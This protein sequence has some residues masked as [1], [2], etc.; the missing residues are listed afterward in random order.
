MRL[1]QLPVWRVFHIYW[2]EDGGLFM[3]HV[4]ISQIGTVAPFKLGESM[5]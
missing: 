5:V 2:V 1:E 3:A 4:R